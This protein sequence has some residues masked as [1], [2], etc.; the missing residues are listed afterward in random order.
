MPPPGSRRSPLG[1][2]RSLAR[3]PL[4]LHIVGRWVVPVLVGPPPPSVAGSRA[5]ARVPDLSPP[6]QALPPAWR[7]AGDGGW[8]T[9]KSCFMIKALASNAAGPGIRRAVPTGGGGLRGGSRP[10]RLPSPVDQPGD[11]HLALRVMPPVV[12]IPLAHRLVLPYVSNPMLH[13]DP[14]LGKRPIVD[15]VLRQREQLKVGGYQ[16][17]KNVPC[18]YWAASDSTA[19]A[20]A[21]NVWTADRLCPGAIPP[22]FNCSPWCGACYGGPVSPR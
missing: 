17:T 14:P 8:V 16:N 5:A 19:E 10:A 20:H 1:P 18:S 6:R 9:H 12:P 7:G 13:H 15:L 22:T 4:L 2:R 11:R 21:E 3:L